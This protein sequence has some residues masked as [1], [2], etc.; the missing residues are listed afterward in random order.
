MRMIVRNRNKN[1]W[2]NG[3]FELIRMGYQ[4]WYDGWHIEIVLFGFM[5]KIIN[6]RHD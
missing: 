6:R 5:L 3:D 1:F 4:K 2:M